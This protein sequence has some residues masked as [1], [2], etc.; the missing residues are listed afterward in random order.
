VRS[1]CMSVKIRQVRQPSRKPAKRG[2]AI[3]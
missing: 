2:T 3:N 1:V